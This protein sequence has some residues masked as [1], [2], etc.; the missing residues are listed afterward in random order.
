MGVGHVCRRCVGKVLDNL[1]RGNA[2]ALEALQ[3]GSACSCGDT[4]AYCRAGTSGGRS[5]WHLLQVD[6]GHVCGRRVGRHVSM[7]AGGAIKAVPCGCWARAQTLCG[8]PGAT[9]G[10]L[11]QSATDGCGPCGR[12][13]RGGSVWMRREASRPCG[14]VWGTYADPVQA[15][16]GVAGAFSTAG[17]RLGFVCRPGV[18]QAGAMWGPSKY[19]T[20]MLGCMFRL[21]AGRQRRR[22]AKARQGCGRGLRVQALMRKGKAGWSRGN[23]RLNHVAMLHVRGY[24]TR[25]S[26]LGA[27]TALQGCRSDAVWERGRFRQECR[28]FNNVQQHAC[29]P[30]TPHPGPSTFLPI[31]FRP[32]PFTP[33]SAA[34]PAPPLPH[35]PTPPGPLAV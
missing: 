31:P 10:L 17:G 26:S 24:G 9:R 33:P 4:V 12:Q 23:K 11:W 35:T 29:Q 7:A 2:G 13:C 22:G 5:R 27:R 16:M 30:P 20:Q 14:R 32:W 19:W 28:P 6:V 18:G 15:G 1:S 25:R 34:L 8:L 21:R 3:V